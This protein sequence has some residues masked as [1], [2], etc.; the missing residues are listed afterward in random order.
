MTHTAFDDSCATL[1][2]TA[3]TMSLMPLGF[4]SSPTFDTTN[5]IRRPRISHLQ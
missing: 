4:V 2:D 1:L 5:H 3:N